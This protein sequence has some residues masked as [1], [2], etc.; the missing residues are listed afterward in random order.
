MRLLVHDIDPSLYLDIIEARF[1][2]LEITTHSIYEGTDDVV[3]KVQPNYVMQQV[4]AGGTYPREAFLSCES[5]EWLHV[6]GAGVNHLAPWDPDKLAVTNSATVQAGTMAQYALGGL[7]SLNFLFP[8]YRQKQ[9][10]HRWDPQRTKSATG[11]TMLIL[12]LGPIGRAVAR[13]ASQFGIHVLGLRR[14]TD[15]VEGVEK[16]FAPDQL[17]EALGLADIVAVVMPLTDATRGLIDAAAFAAMKPGAIFIN[18]ARGP[19][20]DETALVT[21]LREKRLRGAVLDVFSEEPLP[22]ESPLWEF[23]NVIMTPHVSSVFEGWERGAAE[24]FCDNLD[25]HLK[26]EP[27]LNLITPP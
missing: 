25:R 3:K 7:F 17:H 19:I 21:A 13:H 4:F 16:I 5:L 27:M 14:R 6:M 26:G 18:I 15:A 11:Q 8:E 12:G 9:N 1:P 20:V 22:P 2:E 24:L 23:E 10:E